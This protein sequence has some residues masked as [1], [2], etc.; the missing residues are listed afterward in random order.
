M[1]DSPDKNMVSIETTRPFEEGA[2]KAPFRI[3]RPQIGQET[4][5]VSLPE[6]PWKGQD[7]VSH[8]EM[9]QFILA[10]PEE[11]EGYKE[12]LE[13]STLKPAERDYSVRPQI[14]EALRGQIAEYIYVDIL[15][16]V[17]P[18]R[19]T[20]I[21]EK[22]LQKDTQTFYK[23]IE[24]VL[25][26]FVH[27]VELR[28]ESKREVLIK[29]LV[30][31]L[32]IAPQFIPNLPRESMPIFLNK[33][34]SRGMNYAQYFRKDLKIHQ[35]YIEAHEKDLV[36]TS[37]TLDGEIVPHGYQ[38]YDPQR[39]FDDLSCVKDITKENL[40]MQQLAVYKAW[41][42]FMSLTLD[43]QADNRSV[44]KIFYAILAQLNPKIVDE[45]PVED[46]AKTTES[47]PAVTQT[48][49]VAKTK[50]TIE[51]KTVALHL[52][53]PD[54][55]VTPTYSA[56][57]VWAIF[58]KMVEAA[59]DGKIT[60]ILKETYGEV[61]K[62]PKSKLTAEQMDAIAQK[63]NELEKSI[64]SAPERE[65]STS[66]FHLETET[67][68]IGQ[69]F[70]FLWQEL[71]NLTP[72]TPRF[73]V[74][75]EYLRAQLA[76]FKAEPKIEATVGDVEKLDLVSKTTSHSDDEQLTQKLPKVSK[77]PGE[78]IVSVVPMRDEASPLTPPP[79]G[80]VYQPDLNAETKKVSQEPLAPTGD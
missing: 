67:K 8:D 40:S 66:D 58:N 4:P 15:P 30:N 1:T 11:L 73:K 56:E 57:D 49:E 13:A 46:T 77:E 76:T 71:S 68:Q 35:N 19:L 72:G 52:S 2:L 78:N 31:F 79:A 48:A 69:V 53:A 12:V 54:F 21:L 16:T 29:A 42:W 74:V 32:A 50:T 14:G 55:L 41:Y 25:L 23:Y 45:N 70:A 27:L 18:E 5:V 33:F 61:P 64:Q 26:K 10:N 6:T 37:Y 47:T 65:L 17:P 36:S 39:T 75:I 59:R 38:Q 24:Q 51:P 60:T 28:E 63:I 3:V 9:V 7:A 20:P 43:S 80:Q 44:R 22:L 62:A 34:I